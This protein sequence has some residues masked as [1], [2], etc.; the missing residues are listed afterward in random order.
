MKL[1]KSI[2][3][4]NVDNYMGCVLGYA[5]LFTTCLHRLILGKM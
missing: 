3:P 5:V 4:C 1:I 2:N